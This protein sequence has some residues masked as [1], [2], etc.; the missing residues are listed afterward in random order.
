M[1]YIQ[2][3]RLHNFRNY[4]TASLSDIESGFVVL[5]GENGAGK[6][7]LLEALSYISPGR[8]LRGAKNTELQNQKSNDP[9]ETPWA[10][11]TCVQT[12]F[13]L[14]KIGTGKNLHNDRRIIKVQGEIVKSQAVLSEYISCIW[15]TPQM[16]SLFRGGASERRRFIDRLLL[17]YDPAHAGRITRYENAMSQ[18]SKILRAEHRTPTD[19]SWLKGLEIQMAETGV[20]IAAARLAFLDR[21][22]EASLNHKETTFPYARL[23]YRGVLEER[24]HSC[25]AIEVEEF[26]LKSLEHSRDIDTLTGRASIGVHRTDLH[27]VYAD[28]N[29]EAHHCSTGEQ[30]AL[31]IGL[32]LAHA[33]LLL[34]DQ[35]RPPL[36]LLDEV[37]AHLDEGR[38]AS[39]FEILKHMGNQ[40]WMT[41]TETHIFHSIQPNAQFFKVK[42]GLIEGAH[43]CLE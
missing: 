3:I 28:K 18:R 27:V 26:F 13:G 7:N 40:V 22:Q 32:I 41:G 20:A 33:R 23:S 36:L 5:T 42:N 12:S 30:K 34:A 24:L 14:I 10:I 15:L 4:E 39:L 25:A 37:A 35:G 16:D 6:T 19:P 21:L 9:K 29:M 2:S 31:L 38:R 1:S 17:T 11:S 8:G 43:N